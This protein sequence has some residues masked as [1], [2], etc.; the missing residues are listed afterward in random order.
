MMA[1]TLHPEIPLGAAQPQ[2][3]HFNQVK[4]M[5]LI[6]MITKTKQLTT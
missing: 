1:E 3:T 6:D 4:I 5:A 2:P